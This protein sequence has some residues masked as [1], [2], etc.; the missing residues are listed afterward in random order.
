MVMLRRLDEC[1]AV[2]NGEGMDWLSA[3]QIFESKSKSGINAPVCD[4]YRSAVFIRTLETA[5]LRGDGIRDISGRAY[6]LRLCLPFL[7]EDMEDM[8]RMLGKGLKASE[9]DVGLHCLID[10]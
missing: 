10:A 3:L 1:W 4:F 2:S 9:R 5:S 8:Q 6:A 7:L